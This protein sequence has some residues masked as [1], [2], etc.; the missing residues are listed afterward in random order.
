MAEL[1][2]E[3][4]DLILKEL[5]PPSLSPASEVCRIWQE[6]C[7]K[8]TIP[9]RSYSEFRQ[10]CLLGDHLRLTLSKSITYRFINMGLQYACLGGQVKL[11]ELFIGRGAKN[12]DWALSAARKGHHQDLITLIDEYRNS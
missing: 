10:S 9:I 2:H 8:L 1:P 6:L 5:D 7:I 11:V 3:L 4:T 12:W